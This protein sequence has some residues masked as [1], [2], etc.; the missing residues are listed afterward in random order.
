[1]L[2][3]EVWWAKVPMKGSGE[4]RRPMLIVSDDAFNRNE[5]YAKVMA[6]HLTSVKRLGGPFDW[7]V[8]LPRGTAG[9]ERPSVVKCAEIYT[10]WKENLHGPA[11][12]VPPV[13]MRLVDHALAIALS[14]PLGE[15]EA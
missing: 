10:L 15:A 7:E 13:V 9:I 3:G 8:S 5:R 11:G 1:M 2:R 4:K 14:L 6:V 12:T